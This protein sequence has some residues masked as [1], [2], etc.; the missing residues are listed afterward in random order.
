MTAVYS[1]GLLHYLLMAEIFVVYYIPNLL[2]KKKK[3][4]GNC[5]FYCG[6]ILDLTVNID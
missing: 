2:K 6:Q 3:Q 4:Q 5:Y 1:L